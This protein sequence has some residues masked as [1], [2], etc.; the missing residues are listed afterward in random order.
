MNRRRRCCHPT[1]MSSN[2]YSSYVNAALRAERWPA[3]NGPAITS[4][5][6]G[7][8]AKKKKQ[9]MPAQHIDMSAATIPRPAMEAQPAA[10]E[11]GH[12]HDPEFRTLTLTFTLYL[13]HLLGRCFKQPGRGYGVTHVG[14]SLHHLRPIFFRECSPF[15]NLLRKSTSNHLSEPFRNLLWTLPERFRNLLRNEPTS[16]FLGAHSGSSSSVSTFLTD[17][18]SCVQEHEPRKAGRFNALSDLEIL[19]QC[20]C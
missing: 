17:P 8:C 6:L 11:A 18:T 10:Y 1:T 5:N 2:P 7:P 20:R 13:L 19:S 12:K 9:K 16:N 15:R 3:R 4:G 14:C